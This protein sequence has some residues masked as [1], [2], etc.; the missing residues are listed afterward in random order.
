MKFE[1]LAKSNPNNEL[2]VIHPE[3]GTIIAGE[4][5]RLILIP[6]DTFAALHMV[7][8]DN[9]GLGAA[10]VVMRKTGEM[11]GRF[12]CQQL[13]RL[14]QPDTEEDWI[15]I[16]PLVFGWLGFCISTY[17]L[18]TYDKAAGKFLMTGKWENGFVANKWIEVYGV[19]Q[20]PVD[21]FNTGVWYGYYSELT[22]LDLLCKELQCQA[23]GAPHCEFTIKPK[24]EW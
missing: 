18:E 8:I 1:E 17:N 3:Q 7:L 6:A 15:K 9:A 12:F 20:E 10:K 19:A 5:D 24:S 14:Y 23:M 2:F 4:T 13:K 22:G 11:A 16:G 21:Y